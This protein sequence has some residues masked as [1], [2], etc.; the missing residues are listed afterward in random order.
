MKILT[1]NIIGSFLV[2]SVCF[3]TCIFKK[4]EFPFEPSI[5]FRSMSKK[6]LLDGN[7]QVIEDSI[8]LDINFKDGNGDIGLSVEDTTGQFARR[9]PDKSFNPY[10]YNFY[11]TIYRR[12][13]FT[14]VYERLILPKFIDPVTNTEFETNIHG[15]VPPLA[16]KD[17]QSPIE[18]VIRYN[19]GGLFYDVIGINKRDS[20]RFEVFIYDRALNQSNVITTPAILVN[21]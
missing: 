14:G 18:G 7:G 15:R 19:I 10:Y 3:Q 13:K 17:K 16:P 4:P 9:R 12:N 1:K 20:I 8:F 11:C 6:S 2:L 5:S 21:E